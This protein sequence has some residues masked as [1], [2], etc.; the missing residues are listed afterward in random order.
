METI[1]ESQ[2]VLCDPSIRF[3]H[4]LREMSSKGAINELA[5]DVVLSTET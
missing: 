2:D 4:L 5:D 3:L 1:Y